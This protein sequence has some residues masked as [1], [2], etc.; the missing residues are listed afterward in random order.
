MTLWT[1]SHVRLPLLELNLF[2]FTL[3]VVVLHKFNEVPPSPDAHAHVPWQNQI[4]LVTSC[5]N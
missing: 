4:G 2:I 5:S 3:V 1:Y